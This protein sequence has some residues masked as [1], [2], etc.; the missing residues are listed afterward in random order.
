VYACKQPADPSCMNT[1]AKTLSQQ[2]YWSVLY[3]VARAELECTGL[4]IRIHLRRGS[5]LTLVIW[6]Y[7]PCAISSSGRGPV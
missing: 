6:M 3:A 5:V 2:A 7:A 4:R 1:H